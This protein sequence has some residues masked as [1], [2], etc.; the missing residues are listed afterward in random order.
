MTIPT[1]GCRV[2][3][4]AEQGRPTGRRREEPAMHQSVREAFMPFSK[5]LEGRLDFMYLDVK[6]LVST[7]VGNLLDADDPSA[8]GS[9]PNPLPDIFTLDW[10]DKDTGV[11]A[12]R[13]E[14][15][16]EYR[17]VK[18]S[19]TS[20]AT[21]DQK[22]AVTR[23][24][25]SQQAIDALVTRKL[26]SFENSLRGRDMFAGYDGWPADGQLGLLS[27]AWAMGPLFRFPKFQAAAASGD[28]L[29]MAQECRMTEAGNPGIIPRNVR[30]GLLFTLAGWVTTLPDGDHGRLVFDPVRRLD[31]WMRSGDHPVPLNL[32]IGLQ[33]ALETLGFDPKG[34]DGIIG[35]GTRAALTAFQASL[36]LTQT[37]GVSSVTDVPQE[38]MVALRAGLDARGVAC[39]P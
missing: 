10:F 15:E 2:S 20:L 5:P 39:F 7:G 28:W 26:D 25:T 37:P 34:L 31:D 33:K 18:F 23:L 27:M 24:R 21:T 13:A 19:G 38:T 14:I 36:A 22:G 1:P 4:N 32:T 6:G 11:L 12:D 3:T 30:N 35:K 29:T 9:N 8:F 17:K 16:E